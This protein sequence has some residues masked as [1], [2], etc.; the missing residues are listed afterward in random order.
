MSETIFFFSEWA[1]I[2][3]I[4]VVG[5]MMYVALVVLLRISGSR[6]LSSMN[7]FDFIITVAIGSAFGRALTA[8]G[9]ALAE[10]IVAF[11]L[12][13]SLQYGVAWLQIR[14]P[15]FSDAVTNPP[16]LLYFRNAFLSETMRRQRITEAEIRSAVRKKRLGS[17]D[18]VEA[19]VLEANGDL[20]IIKTVGDGSA[21]GEKVEKQIRG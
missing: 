18:A 4:L 2:S 8:K 3:R 20:S 14:W 9:V 16:K 10:A 5:A 1:P 6:T 19:V 13:V 11:A 21:L 7:A 15:F 12:L 17:M